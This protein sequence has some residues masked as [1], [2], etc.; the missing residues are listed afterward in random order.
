MFRQRHSHTVC[1]RYHF[2]PGCIFRVGTVCS[3]RCSSVLSSTADQALIGYCK[4]IAE[5]NRNK[6][7]MRYRHEPRLTENGEH[8]FKV[9]LDCFPCSAMRCS[10]VYLAQ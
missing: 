5:I 6:Y 7:V 2:S 4:I 1:A 9:R 8:D 3:L 10:A